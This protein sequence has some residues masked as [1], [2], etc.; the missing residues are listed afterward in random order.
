MDKQ[1]VDYCERVRQTEALAQG[2]NFKTAVGKCV[3]G[4][5]AELITQKSSST[6]ICVSPVFICMTT[7]TLNGNQC[8]GSVS[9]ITAL[10]ALDSQVNH[11][12]TSLYL[13][14]E[15]LNPHCIQQG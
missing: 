4:T 11:F 7:P 15:E 13:R 5:F 6:Y 3:C 10:E 8:V 9:V 2:A 14:F 12:I 1:H